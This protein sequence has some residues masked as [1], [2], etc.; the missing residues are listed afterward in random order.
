[1]RPEAYRAG[2]APN[3]KNAAAKSDGAVKDSIY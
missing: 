1:M 3:K 2:T